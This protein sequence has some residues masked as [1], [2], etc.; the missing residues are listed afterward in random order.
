MRPLLIALATLLVGGP[1]AAQDPRLAGRIDEATLARI[2]HVMEQ[3]SAR[4]GPVRTPRSR[5]RDFLHT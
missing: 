5:D 4:S 1:V 3:A 2:T